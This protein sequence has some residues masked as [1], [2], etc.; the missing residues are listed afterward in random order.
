MQQVIPI[1]GKDSLATALVQTAYE[2]G[3]Y[4]F[5]FNDTG[6]EL[7]ETYDW[8][9]EV[10]VKTG[11]KIERVGKNLI[12]LIQQ[13]RFLPSSKKRFCTT[14]GKIKPMEE[15]LG[16]G[17]YT[18]FFGIRADEQR[19]GYKADSK[20]CVITPRFPLHEH[21]I[22]LGG[23]YAILQAKDL[24]PPSFHWPALEQRVDEFWWAGDRGKTKAQQ[25]SMPLTLFGDWREHLSFHEKRVLFAGRSR[26]NCFFCFYQRMYEFCWLADTHPELLDIAVELEETI[27]GDGYTWVQGQTLREI[28]AKRDHYID[29]RAKEIIKY[30]SDRIYK[31]VA[32]IEADNEL[33]HVS[34]GLFCGK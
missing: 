25:K 9:N 33:A 18:V 30:I 14:S 8:L 34:C 13:N 22:T 12:E 5:F 23:V 7:P 16:A 10:Q 29:R 1:S 6:V 2:P 17:E 24:L 26:N 20:K 28:T 31:Q 4:R 19:V 21:G 11:W 3:D 27:G 15:W 32:S